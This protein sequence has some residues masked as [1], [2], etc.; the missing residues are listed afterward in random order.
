MAAARDEFAA[1]GPAGARVDR[2]AKQA[3]V[4]KE[5]VYGHFGSKDR[6]FDAVVAEALEEH[7]AM[8][9]LPT[10]DPAEY[11]GQIY[12][13]HRRNPQLLR[14]MMWE[15]LH[16]DSD[17]PLDEDRRRARYAEKISAL[18]DRLGIASD[19]TAAATLLALIGIAIV[20]VAFPQITR[21]VHRTTENDP[22]EMRHHVMDLAQKVTDPKHS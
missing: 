12:D 7:T 15:A 2:I 16:Y 6:L 4:S 10:G 1:H 19:D 20:P 22:A 11:A 13:L 14:L 17:A 9:G 21:L 18:A 8:L 3:G 5:R